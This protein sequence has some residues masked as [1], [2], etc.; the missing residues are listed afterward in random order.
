M[1]VKWGILGG[2]TLNDDC[3]AAQE[4]A[5]IDTPWQHNREGD[6][7]DVMVYSENPLHAMEMTISR[8]ANATEDAADPTSLLMRRMTALEAE[9]RKLQLAASP[10]EVTD[11]QV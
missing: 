11:S 9:M 5:N 4:A 1:F 3:K 8:T 2:S 10:G 6:D 7:D